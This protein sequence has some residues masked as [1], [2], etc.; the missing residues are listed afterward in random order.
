LLITPTTRRQLLEKVDIKRSI[1]YYFYFIIIIIIIII[2]D[3]DDDD[4]KVVTK[5]LT[6]LI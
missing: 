4:D 5:L 1:R 3:D 6:R 2:I